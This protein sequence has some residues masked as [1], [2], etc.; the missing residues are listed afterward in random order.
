MVTGIRKWLQGF[1]PDWGA[2][3][4]AVAIENYRRGCDAAGEEAGRLRNAIEAEVEWHKAEARH[5]R[6]AEAEITEAESGK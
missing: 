1:A 2:D 5:H 4:R 3:T 6:E